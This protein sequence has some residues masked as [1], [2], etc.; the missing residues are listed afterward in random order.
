MWVAFLTFVVL[1]ALWLPE[2]M[3]EVAKFLAMIRAESEKKKPDCIRDDEF[4]AYYDLIEPRPKPQHRRK[5]TS[6][7]TGTPPPAPRA[8]RE[9]QAQAEFVFVPRANKET[10]ETARHDPM[11]RKVRTLKEIKKEIRAFGEGNPEFRDVMHQ[12]F[13]Q[14]HELNEISEAFDYIG[15]SEDGEKV[16]RY[17]ATLEKTSEEIRRNFCDI[18]NLLVAAGAKTGEGKLE[19]LNQAEV[20]RE[21]M[22]NAEKLQLLREL[23]QEAALAANQRDGVFSAMDLDAEV[24]ASRVHNDLHEPARA[25]SDELTLK[26][27]RRSRTGGTAT[28]EYTQPTI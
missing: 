18:A 1:T 6:A 16:K 20:S 24:Q 11:T 28:Q 2:V 19:N 15:E 26:T 27:A 4:E 8:R 9:P 22:T 13:R 10:E 3:E 7:W 23:L 21:L 17:L 12:V 5:K 14:V 25:P